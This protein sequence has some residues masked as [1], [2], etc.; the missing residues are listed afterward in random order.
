MNFDSSNIIFLNDLQATLF[1]V[2]GG[3]KGFT[4]EAP[5][6]DGMFTYSIKDVGDHL[7]RDINRRFRKGKAFKRVE[8]FFNYSSHNMRLNDLLISDFLRFD[9]TSFPLPFNNVDFKFNADSVTRNWF[10]DTPITVQGVT[11]EE[12]NPF[13][14]G[15]FNASFISKHLYNEV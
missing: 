14:S 12:S 13:K 9:F 10:A 1:F 7:Y 6:G 3:S 2:G 15:S 11:F 8:L 5:N 4:I